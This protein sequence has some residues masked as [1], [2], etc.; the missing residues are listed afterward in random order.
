MNPFIKDLLLAAQNL[1]GHHHDMED[2]NLNP[3]K[4]QGFFM[5]LIDDNN[6]YSTINFFLIAMT[7]V[8]IMLLLVPMAGMIVDMIY[9]HTITINLSDLGTYILAV[10]G[11]F[12]VAGLTNAWTEYSYNK[13]NAN[14]FNGEKPDNINGD[15]IVNNYYDDKECGEYKENN[16]R[17][18]E[19]E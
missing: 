18:K 14:I 7:F 8:G 5:K 6:D 9:N 1:Y 15:K 4:K 17:R 13:Y 12:G 10:S 16:N 19:E 11:I 3:N 2:K